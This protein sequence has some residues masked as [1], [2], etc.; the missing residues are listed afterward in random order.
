GSVEGMAAA[1]AFMKGFLQS[2][3]SRFVSKDTRAFWEDVQAIMGVELLIEAGKGRWS[4][5]EACVCEGECL[6]VDEEG[7]KE[8]QICVKKIVEVGI[9]LLE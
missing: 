2:Y 9:E 5:I 1:S 6:L 4:S 7:V 3:A 8:R